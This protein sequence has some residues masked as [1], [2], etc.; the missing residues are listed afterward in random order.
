MFSAILDN[1]SKRFF[2]FLLKRHLGHLFE[3]EVELHSQAGSTVSF[4]ASKALLN[5]GY[6]NSQ[7]DSPYWEITAGYVGSIKASIPI[8]RLTSSPCHVSVDEIFLE[9]KPGALADLERRASQSSAAASGQ[10]N[11]H[12]PETIGLGDTSMTDNITDNIQYIAGSIEKVLQEL[13]LEAGNVRIHLELPDAQGPGQTCSLVRLQLEKLNYA[14]DA[15]AP[16][17]AAASSA[18][19]AFRKL[20]KRVQFHGLSLELIDFRSGSGTSQDL[21]S[22]CWAEA[23]TSPGAARSAEAGNGDAEEAELEQGQSI[24]CKDDGKGCSGSASLQLT[25][26]TSRHIHPRIG[27]NLI[28]QPVQVQ[29]QPHHPIM[30]VKLAQCM[31]EASQQ[32][33]EREAAAGSQEDLPGLGRSFGTGSHLGGRSF[34]ESVLLPDC[35]SLVEEALPSSSYYDPGTQTGPF[36]PSAPLH[37]RQ[38]F[39]AYGISAPATTCPSISSTEYFQD[40]SSEY[41]DG[42]ASACS[43][44]SSAGSTLRRNISAA[45]RPHSAEGTST[46]VNPSELDL[47]SW[48]VSA[49]AEAVSLVLLYPEEASLGISQELE[50]TSGAYRPRLLVEGGRLGLSL[51]SK[52]QNSIAANLTLARLEAVEHLPSSSSHSTSA[53]LTEVKEL[54]R[55]LPTVRFGER[56]VPSFCGI[57][58]A[59]LRQTLYRST[60][61]QLSS[62][63]ASYAPHGSS[64]HELAI[65]PV[66]CAGSAYDPDCNTH[67]L[68]MAV[69]SRPIEANTQHPGA[70]APGHTCSAGAEEIDAEVHVQQLTV[71]LSFPLLQRLQGFF[72]PVLRHQAQQAMT[73]LRQPVIAP[74]RATPQRSASAAYAEG[75]DLLSDVLGDLKGMNP[76]QR[77]PSKPR[78]RVQSGSTCKAS[79]L[80]PHICV[81]MALPPSASGVAYAAL[82]IF[83]A[84]PPPPAE[85]RRSSRTGAPPSP[86]PSAV[87]MLSVQTGCSGS[88]SAPSTSSSGASRRQ[89]DEWHGDLGLGRAELYLI[90]DPFATD[91]GCGGN[92]AGRKLEAHLVARAVM[93]ERHSRSSTRSSSKS[94]FAWRPSAV[95]SPGL[96]R[97]C[98]DWTRRHAGFSEEA[99]PTPADLSLDAEHICHKAVASSSTSVRLKAASVQLTLSR[100]DLVALSQLLAASVRFQ[101]E[102]HRATWENIGDEEEFLAA[103][104]P[105]QSTFQLQAEIQCKLLSDGQASRHQASSDGAAFHL[106]AKKVRMIQV[107]CIGGELDASLLHLV[108]Q[109]MDVKS[110]STESALLHSPAPSASN[111]SC[112]PIVEFLQMQAP[113]ASGEV[114]A[115]QKQIQ[116]LRSVRL[117]RVT[118]A[119][120]GG[121]VTVGWFESLSKL[122]S[123]G[124]SDESEPVPQQEFSTDWS[125]RLEEAAVRYEPPSTSLPL[126]ASAMSTTTTVSADPM[127]AVL[128]I[129]QLRWSLA[130]GHMDSKLSLRSLQLLAGQA[131]GRGPGFELSQPV[132]MSSALLG[133][134]G[135]CRLAQEEQLD[136]AVQPAADSPPGPFKVDISNQKLR[137]AFTRQ[138]LQVFQTFANQLA[139]FYA[140]A[141]SPTQGF[142]SRS[143][144]PCEPMVEASPW[145]GD[146]SCDADAAACSSNGPVHIMEGVVPDAFT[147]AA[148]DGDAQDT[149]VVLGAQWFQSALLAGEDEP[150]LVAL[151]PVEASGQPHPASNSRVQQPQFA[152][153]NGSAGSDG[154]FVSV[155]PM[156]N[157]LTDP[158]SVQRNCAGPCRRSPMSIPADSIADRGDAAPH[159]IEG[160]IATALPAGDGAE[161]GTQ[162]IAAALHQRLA[163]DDSQQS[164]ATPQQLRTT[165]APEGTGTWLTSGGDEMLVMLQEDH[166]QAPAD[167]RGNDDAGGEPADS[168]SRPGSGRHGRR[169]ALADLSAEYPSPATRIRLCHLSCLF[170]VC[171]QNDPDPGNSKPPDVPDGRLEIAL[172]DV[173]MQVDLFG[174]EEQ[175]VSRLAVSIHQLDVQDC[176]RPSSPAQRTTRLLTHHA[177]VRHPRDPAAPMFQVELETVRTSNGQAGGAEG[178]GAEEARMRVA[179]LPLRLRL[180]K[181]VITFLCAFIAPPD[182]NYADFEAV[183]AT[184]VPLPEA[185]AAPQ[186]AGSPFF[187]KVDVQGFSV[188]IE[189]QQQRVDVAALWARQPAEIANL[190][191]WGF[192][193]LSLPSLTL[194]GVAGW[195]QLLTTIISSY[196]KD[197][198]MHK[199][200]TAVAPIQALCRVGSALNDLLAIPAELLGIAT[201]SP[202]H[203]SRPLPVSHKLQRSLVSLAKAV[204]VEALS[205][206]AQVAHGTHVVLQ[207]RP[208]SASAAPTPPPSFNTAGA[209]RAASSSGTASYIPYAVG[210]SGMGQVVVRAIKAAPGAASEAAAAVRVKILGA[211]NA[212][213]P[214]RQHDTNLGDIR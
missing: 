43:Y 124:S 27:A 209:R 96:L 74:S 94:S 34:L 193:Q 37:H 18:R 204:T 158:H 149:S 12:E 85:A 28:L 112:P 76:G 125:V 142:P 47:A 102:A 172:E 138:R 108:C 10:D 141:P 182:P 103:C 148:I 159:V 140:L 83:C 41:G 165:V 161:A 48:Q 185:P 44:G 38:P 20:C 194:K 210:P 163:A 139:A 62:L 178:V 86:G 71:W 155:R 116:Q 196:N 46:A 136:I 156:Q 109:G 60:L 200:V 128:L 54:P 23:S 26:P 36:P 24:I 153:A 17:A 134:A 5:C 78:T 91:L 68:R 98:W 183:D 33:A 179:L 82:D 119:S 97:D 114:A 107:G 51:G 195:P 147:G 6:L 19:P 198:K 170:E 69:N 93:P 90:Q 186:P 197:I 190:V 121:D 55:H 61:S 3:N 201:A 56:P 4:E 208:S 104:P 14:G 9:V 15:S 81:L 184:A 122:L 160:F 64:C 115:S 202:S 126:H 132:D 213:D 66:L 137:C 8:T 206:G 39:H 199:L 45:A 101:E 173:C 72:Q 11:A 127:A 188:M 214:D 16:P 67:S 32:A 154:H 166:F 111:S 1:V 106:T 30:L 171:H 21:E 212:L 175:W 189:F 63:S 177:S 58:L 117:R 110:A 80:M 25:W 133:A 123:L 113:A 22:S 7:L 77:S 144:M 73:S 174:A 35:N 207:G 92:L 176:S 203:G 164:S 211:R 79:L 145:A 95:N 59:P 89:G 168:A 192:L 87:P 70:Q 131:E 143:G 187:Q 157:S 53:A 42:F 84:L 57:S 181:H 50:V 13:Q 52:Q 29:L 146:D 152:A 169:G 49:S 191:P 130:C 118:L 150:V 162:A 2:K 99:E 135:Y 31:S 167:I 65:W 120:E 151:E 105:T 100:A 205:L 180:D 75:L 129:G 40:A 88:G